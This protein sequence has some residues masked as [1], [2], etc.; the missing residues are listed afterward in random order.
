MPARS[1]G[2]PNPPNSVPVPLYRIER[3]SASQVGWKI[4]GGGTSQGITKE[5]GLARGTAEE[6][7]KNIPRTRDKISIIFKVAGVEQLRVA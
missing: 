6:S 7:K 5:K 1:V 2:L 4:K 3:I